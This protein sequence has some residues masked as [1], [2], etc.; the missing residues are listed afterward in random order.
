MQEELTGESNTGRP[1][2]VVPACPAHG[3]N[4]NI[5]SQ[6]R[7]LMAIT[8]VTKRTGH[9]ISHEARGTSSQIAVSHNTT[10][11]VHAL[12]GVGPATR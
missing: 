11:C 1:T 12:C 8:P 5:A 7:S 6:Q 9:W 4:A 3:N 2:I 10:L